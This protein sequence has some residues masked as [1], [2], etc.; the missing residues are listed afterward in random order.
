[1]YR[2]KSGPKKKVK[3][4]RVFYLEKLI[5]SLLWQ[6]IN[7]PKIL[8]GRRSSSRD[9]NISMYIVSKEFTSDTFTSRTF[10]GNYMQIS[11]YFH[12]HA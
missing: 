12:I 10:V 11:I 2:N 7:A 8:K 1:M 6:N 9:I 4:I 5:R 3:H